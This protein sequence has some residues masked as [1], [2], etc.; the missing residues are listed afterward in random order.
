MGRGVWGR[1][2]ES[3]TISALLFSSPPEH[4]SE[5]EKMINSKSI[6]K[7]EDEISERLNI[8]FTQTY[9][10]TLEITETRVNLPKRDA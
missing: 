3:L 1:G 8:S 5:F 6:K 9:G 4:R 2:V 10:K 7:D